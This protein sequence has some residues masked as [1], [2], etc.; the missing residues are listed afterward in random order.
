MTY[1]ELQAALKPYKQDGLTTIKL[2]TSNSR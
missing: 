1:K 2:N